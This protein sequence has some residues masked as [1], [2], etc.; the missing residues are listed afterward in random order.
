[1]I[2]PASQR[3]PYKVSTGSHSRQ[4]DGGAVS[5]VPTRDNVATGWSAVK[6]RMLAAIFNLMNISTS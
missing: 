6:G 1:M 3:S 2:A 4:D 5:D